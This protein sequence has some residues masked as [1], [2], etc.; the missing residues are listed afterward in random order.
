LRVAVHWLRSLDSLS[1]CTGWTISERPIGGVWK[2]TILET[3]LQHKK[4]ILSLKGKR[5]CPQTKEL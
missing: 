1:L 5:A 2:S 3:S 4:I